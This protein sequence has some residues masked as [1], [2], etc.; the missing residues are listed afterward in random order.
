MARGEGGVRAP[1][2]QPN[3]QQQQQ[4]QQVAPVT[5]PTGANGAAAAA[6]ATTGGGGGGGGGAAAVE[7]V[8]RQVLEMFPGSEAAVRELVAQHGLK[9]DV[10]VDALLTEFFGGAHGQTASSAC[11]E[12]RMV[13]DCSKKRGWWLQPSTC[14]HCLKVLSSYSAMKKHAAIR[15]KTGLRACGSSM[16]RTSPA[17]AA[18]SSKACTSPAPVAAVA[19]T[20]AAGSPKRA[21]TTVVELQATIAARDETIAG[22]QRQLQPEVIDVDAVDAGGVGGTAASASSKTQ[23]LGQQAPPSAMEQLH[24]AQRAATE[25]KVERDT[26]RRERDDATVDQQD[27]RLYSALFIDQLQSKIDR[28]KELCL[29]AGVTGAAVRHAMGQS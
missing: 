16:A 8:V 10:V 29:G 19:M 12:P 21:S 2:L 14:K 28:L 27:D 13:K 20:G 25:I 9:P 22:L 7:A 3:E 6:A 17:P 5:P 15:P 4:Q 18:G 23:V 11:S 24:S 26:A 1:L